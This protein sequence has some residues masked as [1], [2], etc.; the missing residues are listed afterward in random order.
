MA[1]SDRLRQRIAMTDTLSAAVSGA[2]AGF[3][4]ARHTT[5]IDWILHILIG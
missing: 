2:V 5:K 1:S 4:L 3:L